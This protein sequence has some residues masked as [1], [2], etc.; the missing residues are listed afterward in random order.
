MT[1]AYYWTFQAMMGVTT[2]DSVLD[3]GNAQIT[4]GTPFW[5]FLFVM[6]VSAIYIQLMYLTAKFVWVNRGDMG[7]EAFSE[8]ARSMTESVNVFADKISQGLFSGGQSEQTNSNPKAKDI[9]GQK[10][11]VRENSKIGHTEKFSVV[12]DTRQSKSES[13]DTEMREYEQANY[14]TG[15]TKEDSKD[16]DDSRQIDAEIKKGK[17]VE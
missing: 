14:T 3:L 8:M 7:F 1:L 12:S 13:D 16:F 15:D 6:I 17:D 10:D 11:G 2:Y 5:C 9:S 4:T